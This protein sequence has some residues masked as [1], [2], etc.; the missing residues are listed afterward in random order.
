MTSYF[1]LLAPIGLLGLL[2]VAA[3]IIIYIIKPNY[4]QKHVS[5]TFVWHLSLRYRRKRIP[6]SRLRNILLIICQVALLIA[7]AFIL[8]FPSIITVDN[9]VY[10][11]EVVIILD[12]SASMLTENDEGTTRFERAVEKVKEISG[13]MRGKNGVVS[14]IYADET[15]RY[16]A[17][18]VT[19]EGIDQLTND[20]DKLIAEGEA[21]GCTYGGSKT[22]KAIEMTESVLSV[23]PGAAVCLI[24]D[25]TYSYVPEEVKV[26]GVGDEQEFNIAVLNA[27][28]E[29]EDGY[30][31]FSVDVAAYGAIDISRQAEVTVYVQNPNATPDQP[32]VQPFIWSATVNFDG[33]A[34]VNVVFRLNPEFDRVGNVVY[35][36][37]SEGEKVITF[38]SVNVQVSADDSFPYDDTFIIYGGVKEQLKIQYYS[39]VISGVPSGPNPFFYNA[40]S[41]MRSF[42]ESSYD[43][44]LDEVQEGTDDY[45]LTGYDLYV[46]EHV[47]PERLPTDG[48]VLL[49]DPYTDVPAEAGFKVDRVVPLDKNEKNLMTVGELSDHP[50]LKYLDAEEITVTQYVK[51]SDCS[52]F[53]V[54]ATV[55]GNPA[56]MAVKDGANQLAVVAFSLHYSNLPI[57]KGHFINLIANI[58]EYYFPA[59]ADG[60]AFEVGESVTLNSR[61]ES[62]TLEKYDMSVTEY[63]EVPVSVTLNA[64][65]TYTLR[66][67]TYF[68]KD[69]I[70]RVFVRVPAKEC[71]IWTKE[72]GIISPYRAVVK[73]DVIDD[74]LLYFA[75]ALVFFMFAE[76]LL[77]L[78]ANEGG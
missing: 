67:T 35:V 7:A 36:P 4:Q 14:L 72:D 33:N 13:E 2:G 23:N 59:T 30:Y 43:I 20:L 21:F 8:A 58:M 37:I 55:D 70:E 9:T 57:L 10:D 16:I 28:A 54:L 46:F 15:P 53:D 11:E 29:K 34:P 39:G 41:Q 49:F 47:M 18:R 56:I 22:D 52:A 40:L 1:T 61:G 50:V 66:Q 19:G 60:Y 26:V 76:W 75:I 6:T 69:V 17:D 5:T 73:E 51:L 31:Y 42:F 64:P 27:Y 62:I 68:D 48:V 74:L 25:K 45:Q 65:G 44:V 12:A 24:T 77:N 63:E 38:E 71:E 78:K 3:L 32:Y